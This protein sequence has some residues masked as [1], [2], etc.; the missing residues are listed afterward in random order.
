VQVFSENFAYQELLPQPID[1]IEQKGEKQVFLPFD[2]DPEKEDLKKFFPIKN[3]REARYT[4][5][6]RLTED[7]EKG[8]IAKLIK[9]Y[10]AADDPQ[11]ATD[12]RLEKATLLIENFKATE[13]LDARSLLGLSQRFFQYLQDNF[14]PKTLDR[15][16]PVSYLWQGRL[17]KTEI[18]LVAT[19]P[20]NRLLLLQGLD[21]S[22][23]NKDWKRRAKAQANALSLAAAAL[24][25]QRTDAPSVLLGVH[26][27]A[28]G[29][30]AF[31]EI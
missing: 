5:P 29:G 21:F 15:Q 19:L 18:D 3:Y 7:A 6:I 4:D 25:S 2:I 12:K 22:G 28:V 17:F 20:N 23:S 27:F 31:F 10:L 26:F 9:A 14:Q 1:Y 16:L 24:Q 30:L 11:Q 8:V 13:M